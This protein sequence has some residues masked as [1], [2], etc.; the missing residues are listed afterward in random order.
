[1]GL[2]TLRNN[3]ANPL[4][5]RGDR[6]QGY[7]LLWHHSEGLSRRNQDVIDLEGV[8]NGATKDGLCHQERKF[9]DEA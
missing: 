4:D 8:N 1:M 5:S 3:A 7:A 2:Q 9:A 6:R